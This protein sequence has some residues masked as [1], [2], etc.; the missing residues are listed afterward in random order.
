VKTFTFRIAAYQPLFKHRCPSLWLED[1]MRVAGLDIS[2]VTVNDDDMGDDEWKI[3]VTGDGDVLRF[4]CV[5]LNLHAEQTPWDTT[6]S[7][8]A[9]ALEDYLAADQ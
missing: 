3:Q 5:A 4:A 1:L 7:E 6:P 9:M 8:Q 2:R